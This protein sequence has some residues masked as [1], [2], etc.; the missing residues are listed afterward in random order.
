MLG[1]PVKIMMHRCIVDH[2]TLAWWFCCFLEVFKATKE[3]ELKYN[4]VGDLI[5]KN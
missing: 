3:S 2:Q 4:F 5:S 1:F